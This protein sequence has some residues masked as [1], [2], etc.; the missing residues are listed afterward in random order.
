MVGGRV[1]RVGPGMRLSMYQVSRLPN[2]LTVATAQLPHLASVSLGLWLGVG[3]RYE[4]AE[5]NGVTH[6][7]EHMLFK[8]TR[9]RSARQISEA[10]EG[11]GGY[12]NAF[13]SEENTCFYARVHAAHFEAV[14]DVIMDM[15]LQSR[16]DP[17]DVEKERQV[18]KEE[19]AS[20]LDQPHHHVEELINEVVWPNQPLG[21][22]LTGT[23]QTIDRLTRQQMLD[24]RQRHYVAATAL[25]AAAGRVAHATVLRAARRYAPRFPAGPR[26]SFA[27]A[28]DHQTAPRLRLCTRAIAQT[29][30]IL[31]IRT[32]SRH[33]PRRHALRVLNALLGESMS[34][35]LFQVLREDT[36][37]AYSVHSSVSFFEDVG[38]L[39]IAVGLDTENL[40]RALRLI[41]RELRRLTVSPP[42]RREC[43]Q[44]RDYLI[45][46]LELSLESTENQMM[47]LAEHLLA[48]GR[49]VPAAEAKRC[50][51]A[52]T[53]A[54]VQAAARDF[55]R[56]DRLN[57]ALVS[58]LKRAPGLINLLT[59]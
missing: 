25:V 14:L 56:P 44:A 54:Q 6:F 8:G 11:L 10:V 39:E 23:F 1:E 40:T 38:L 51:A 35:R 13:T 58:P 37:L 30:F 33:D 12:L 16:F 2:G 7:I 52:V 32:C 29:Q 22:P 27:P 17:A 21:R 4:P 31:G 43:Q 53:P 42:S 28:D 19:L 15:F 49:P 41:G 48:Y 59:G 26:P 45:G 55:F 36:G 46:Q 57:L 50:V 9:R 47:W 20:Y 18:I 34:S 3:G 24:Y 5:L